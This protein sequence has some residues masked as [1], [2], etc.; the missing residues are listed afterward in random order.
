MI[1]DLAFKMLPS[2]V[3]ILLCWRQFN[4]T[5]VARGIEAY[6]DKCADFEKVKASKYPCLQ[7]GL[8][9][10]SVVTAVISLGISVVII[11]QLSGFSNIAQGGSISGI[12]TITFGLLYAQELNSD[13]FTLR[14]KLTESS[15]RI[16]RSL[17]KNPALWAN[18]FCTGAILTYQLGI[19]FIIPWLMAL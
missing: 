3:S 11:S 7:S 19:L 1:W 15:R 8:T 14:V 16:F 5:Q 6:P 17:G 9:A 18:I 13:A 2:L 4:F 10:L 12:L